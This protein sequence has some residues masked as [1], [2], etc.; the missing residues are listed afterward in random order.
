MQQGHDKPNACWAQKRAHACK[1]RARRA[2]PRAHRRRL[3]LRVP[4][5]LVLASARL[6][7]RR[8]WKQACSEPHAHGLVSAARS[9][10]LP[11]Q[12]EPVPEHILLAIV[13]THGGVLRHDT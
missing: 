6:T 10:L 2:D 1:L 8:G 9:L 12:A 5:A 4:A 11:A 7:A 3:A 13:I